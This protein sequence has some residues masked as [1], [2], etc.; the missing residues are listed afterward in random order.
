MNTLQKI[1]THPLLSPEDVNVIAGAHKKINIPKDTFLLKEGQ[2]ANEYYCLESGLTR[3]F[4]IDF[5]GNDITTNF[6]GNNEVVIEVN[7]LFQRI[8]SKE[9]IQAVTDCVCWKIVFDDFQQLFHSI[10]GLT[11][12]GRAW[13]SQELFHFK[14]R[15]VSMITDTATDRYLALQHKRPQILQDAPLKHIASYLGITDTSLSRIR[16]EV[17]KK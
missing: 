13:M 5:N 4:V 9:N 8:P 17:A 1:Y 14:Q 12:W 2:T 7:S 15:S 10:V 16:K 6:F 3:S 11:E